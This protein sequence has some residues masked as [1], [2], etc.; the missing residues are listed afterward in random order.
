MNTRP[1]RYRVVVLTSYQIRTLDKRR[2]L[3]DAHLWPYEA[4]R[5]RAVVLTSWDRREPDCVSKPW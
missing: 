3:S 4:T 5:Y 2:W 1:T